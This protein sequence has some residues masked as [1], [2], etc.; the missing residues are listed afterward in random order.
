MN[1]F[2]KEELEKI[3]YYVDITSHIQ[4]DDE[5]DLLDKIQ[6][7]IDNYCDHEWYPGGNRPWL[8]CIKC[9]SNFHHED[10]KA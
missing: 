6:S 9:K 3:F 8:H 4:E 1:D 7:M 5:Q 10:P 2:T